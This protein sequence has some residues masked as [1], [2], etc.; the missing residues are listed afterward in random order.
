MPAGPF[1]EWAISWGAAA[2]KKGREQV[3]HGRRGARQVEVDV[4]GREL[5]VLKRVEPQPGH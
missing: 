5:A 2:W 3:L 4:M 1:T